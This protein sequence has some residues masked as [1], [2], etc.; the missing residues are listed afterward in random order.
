VKRFWAELATTEIAAL[1]AGRAIA[2]LPV[3]ATEQHGPHLPLS[4]DTAILD[5]IIGASL[6]IMPAEL[7]VLFLPTLAI[8]K[9]NEHARY[10]GTLTLGAETLLRVWREIAASVAAAGVRKLVLFNSHGGQSALMEVA[11]RDIREAHDML[12]FA[13]N[14]YM[15]GLPEGMYGEAELRHGIHGGDLETSMMLALSPD[16]VRMAKAASVDSATEALA[17]DFPDI[18][19]AG[20]ARIGWMTQ[21][22]NPAGACGDASRAT[23]EKGRA[24]IAHV[25]RRFVEVLGEI[26]RLPLDWLKRGGADG[27]R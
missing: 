11:V 14:W 16:K 5:G 3:A 15:L 1:P 2:I 13:V 22:M 26:D 27:A 6:E 18:G 8:G 23:A 19:L 20:P 21:D 9:S 25:A 17:R 24:T 10:P 12:A 4:V 7:P